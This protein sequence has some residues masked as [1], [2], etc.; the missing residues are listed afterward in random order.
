MHLF[1]HVQAV[2][3]V[4]A[5]LLGSL[6]ARSDAFYNYPRPCVNV[7]PYPHSMKVQSWASNGSLFGAYPLPSGAFVRCF[8]Q[9]TGVAASFA[10]K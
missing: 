9:S 10:V 8:M 6:S 7:P 5:V 3:T 1:Q 4:T 2:L